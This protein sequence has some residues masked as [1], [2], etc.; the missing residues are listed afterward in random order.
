MGKK[1]LIVLMLVCTAPA[2]YAQGCS[3]CA[4]TAGELGEKE[5]QSLNAGIIYLALLPMT[6]LGTVGIV[7]WRHNRDVN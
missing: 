7:W 4:K 1:L 2:V 5:A 6:I 3:L